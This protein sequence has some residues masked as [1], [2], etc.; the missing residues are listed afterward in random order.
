MER[1]TFA[2]SVV[3]VAVVAG[4][5]VFVFAQLRP[6]LLFA[7][8]TPAGGDMGAHV[9][10]PAFLRDHLLPHWRLTGWAPDW[11]AGFPALHFYFPLPS[12]AIVLANS[13]LPYA[14]A[15]KLVTVVGVVSLPV[16]AYWCTRLIGLRYPGP[17]IA[18]A[19]T[20]PFLFDRHHTIYGGNVAATLA[21]EFSFSIGLSL[22]LAFIGV[23]ARGLET[24][25]G[26]GWA[27][28]LLAATALCHLLT[29][30][31]AVAGA[32]L[33]LLFRLDA[34]RLR[35]ALTSLPV[36]FLLVSWWVLPFWYRLPYSNDMGWEKITAYT[37]NLF[38]FVSA[39][40]TSCQPNQFP[41]SQTWHL[42][43]VT[44]L[45]GAGVVLAVVRA[46]REGLFLSALAAAAAITFVAAPQARLWNAR[47][48]PFWFLALYLL[49]AF[50]LGELVRMAGERVGARRDPAAPGRLDETL[51]LAAGP[52]ALAVAVVFAALPL[53]SLPRF[54]P[55][56]T[57]DHS[58]I[59]DW[60]RWNYSGYERK[61]KYP[62]YRA[63]VAT[64]ARVGEQYGCGRALWEY[65]PELDQYGTPMA[66]MLLPFWTHECIG[67]MEGL[68]F[69]SS[70]S[71]PYHFLM[72][73][74]LSKQP[75]RPQ[76]NLPYVDL[77]LD[78]GVQQLQL[79][80]VRYYMAV[81]PEA[82]AAAERQPDL[83][84]IASSGPW[85]VYLV[86]GS[87]LV[88]GLD[89]APAVVE[90]WPKG[91]DD[92]MEVAVPWFQ[93]PSRWD[94]LLAQDGPKDWPRV[95][96]TRKPD[97]SKVY[98]AGVTVSTPKQ[99]PVEPVKA[100]RIRTSDDR[101]SFDVDRVGEPVL[102]KASY[103][104]NWQASGA[105]GPWR[106]SPNLM[107]VIPTA[108][109]VELHYGR[110]PID[111]LGIVFTLGGLVALVALRRAGPVAYREA[112]PVAEAAG[113]P[114]A[115]SPGEAGEPLTVGSDG[116]GRT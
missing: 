42:A 8:T 80:G 105:K 38:P 72:Q 57:T 39:C 63:V 83:V 14:V 24:G 75:S 74:E 26:R 91:H 17:A 78:L 73:S 70:A 59:P 35:Y 76:R 30:L 48:L 22:A 94:V 3:D 110:T 101:I 9:W 68:F 1:R 6:D 25:R 56:S 87:D 16:A 111:W 106:V 33:L 50:A 13:V 82:I 60:V 29:T 49:A 93:D 108:R 52:V 65:K 113:E 71:T 23:F 100:S 53:G 97:P 116:F 85:Q 45:A 69:E 107:V 84:R 62:E 21:G 2:R 34:R 5:A 95:R 112:E 115:G 90:G 88:E 99:V 31:F 98:G 67:S 61:D 12:L 81:S 79:Y 46:R 10:G 96:V 86:E 104:P 20:V 43:I 28:V 19:A 58:F 41:T 109:H 27:A 103:F 92:W 54:V 47:A 37:K 44:L 7:N 66:L 11:Y 114:A 40:G 36:A 4:A 51:R 15:F 89:H 64:M 18:A 55:L 32:G 77:D 102:V